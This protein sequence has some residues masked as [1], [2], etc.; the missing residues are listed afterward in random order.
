MVVALLTMNVVS[1]QHIAAD[2]HLKNSDL[3]AF[4]LL[5]V[6]EDGEAG[7]QVCLAL[8]NFSAVPWI[9]LEA[10]RASFEPIAQNSRSPPSSL[11]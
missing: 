4:C 6:F 1:G 3:C 9:A 7:T 2:D 8:L 10:G 5:E 11:S